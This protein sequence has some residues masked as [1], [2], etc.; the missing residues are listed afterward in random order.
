MGRGCA[1]SYTDAEQGS[2]PRRSQTGVGNK[3]AS[4][5]LGAADAHRLPE[6]DAADG[7]LESG[8]TRRVGCF[9]S[10][11]SSAEPGWRS[12]KRSRAWSRRRSRGV[13]SG[14][15]FNAGAISAR[16]QPP[17]GVLHSSRLDGR[18]LP[19]VRRLAGI[20]RGARYR[21]E[22]LPA[23]WPLWRTVASAL[24]MLSLLRHDRSQRIAITGARE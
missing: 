5:V 23:L 21:A 9:H 1:A 3:F 4:A 14:C 17:L 12:Y 19:C 20:Y 13:S 11:Q 24:F 7:D 6:R 10:V 8:V 16:L 18:L 22:P 15:G 2:A